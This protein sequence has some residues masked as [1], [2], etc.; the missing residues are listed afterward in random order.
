MKAILALIAQ[1]IIAAALV[2]GPV[3][4]WLLFVMQP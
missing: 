1:G 4:Y 3:F 2:G